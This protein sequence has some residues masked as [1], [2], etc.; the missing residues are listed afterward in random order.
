[1]T[2][3]DRLSRG[4]DAEI[5]AGNRDRSGDVAFLKATLLQEFAEN[6]HLRE[7]IQELRAGRPG[8]A[9]AIEDARAVIIDAEIAKALAP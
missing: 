1:M 5:A 3:I 6:R 9:T 8:P 4:I 7:V 2:A